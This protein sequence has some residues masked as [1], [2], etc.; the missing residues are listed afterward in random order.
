M[1]EN[2][3]WQ[4]RNRLH[5]SLQNFFENCIQWVFLIF[6]PSELVN[7]THKKETFNIAS[8]SNLFQVIDES[9]FGVSWQTHGDRRPYG[10][11]Q[12]MFIFA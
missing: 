5:K 4:A 3:I 11:K 8:A 9:L 12:G 6:S 7:Q 1:K 10:G 2:E